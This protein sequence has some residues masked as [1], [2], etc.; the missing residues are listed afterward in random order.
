MLGRPR[1]RQTMD[2]REL[3]RVDRLGRAHERSAPAGLH[4]DEDVAAAV[5]AD[6]IELAIPG[7]GVAG[8]DPH[9][10][11]LERAGRGGFTEIAKQASSIGHAWEIG[12]PLRASAR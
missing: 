5:A 7:A 6:E 8:D 11:T 12:A 1:E 2:A 3:A 10:G 4:L 9:A